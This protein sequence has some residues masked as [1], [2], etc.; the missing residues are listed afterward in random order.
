MEEEHLAERK[1]QIEKQREVYKSKLSGNDLDNELIEIEI[2]D[3][4]PPYG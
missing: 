1:L 3:Q 4:K 2:E